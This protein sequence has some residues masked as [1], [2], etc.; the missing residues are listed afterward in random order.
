MIV[1]IYINENCEP[2]HNDGTKLSEWEKKQVYAACANRG[3]V[4][5]QMEDG[6]IRWTPEK[7]DTDVFE[8]TFLK[9][10]SHIQVDLPYELINPKRGGS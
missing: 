5:D 8:Q 6:E 7:I 3:L 1:K 9:A 4:G 10:N 2:L